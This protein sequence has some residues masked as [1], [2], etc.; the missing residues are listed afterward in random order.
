ML[1]RPPPQFRSRKATVS[2]FVIPVYRRI[3]EEFLAEHLTCPTTP[4]G[5]KEIEAGFRLR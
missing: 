3:I 4:E 2:K 5:W 1:G